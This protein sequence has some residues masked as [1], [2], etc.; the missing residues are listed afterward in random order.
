MMRIFLIITAIVLG[1]FALLLAGISYMEGQSL[2]YPDATIHETPEDRGL[3]Y[4]EVQLKSED[5]LE[6]TAWSLPSL[7]EAPEISPWL[8]YLHGNGGNIS[9]MMDYSEQLVTQGINTLLVEYRGYMGNA[10]EPSEQGMYR[11]ARAGYD[12]LRAQGV[13]AEAIIIHGHSL[14]AGVASH[15]ASQ[16]DSAGLILEAPFANT[17]TV[18]RA[19]ISPLLYDF[20]FLRKRFN[21]VGYVATINVPL[22]VLHA[23]DDTFISEAMSQEVYEAA[24][25]PKQFISMV[26]AGG[27]KGLI[28]GAPEDVLPVILNFIH[29]ATG[30]PTTP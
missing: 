27:H 18:A 11:D 10:G 7:S 28:G 1:L 17:P 13:A 20:L 4:H 19:Q 29:T 9:M 30:T 2:F 3:E 22:L 6:L 15:L 14:G 23:E 5:G 12:Y 26:G 16:V 21:T 25:E 24:L 8:L